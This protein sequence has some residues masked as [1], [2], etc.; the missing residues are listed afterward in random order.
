MGLWIE[1][2]IERDSSA[3]T[4]TVELFK[5]WK[6]WCEQGN[7][8]LGTERSFSDELADHGFER[9]KLRHVRGFKGLT[10]RANDGPRL[11]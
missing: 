7:H 1:T 2:W 5:V 6:V 10:L 3:F 9:T 11:V 4:S 8:Y